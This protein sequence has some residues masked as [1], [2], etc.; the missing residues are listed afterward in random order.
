ML[1]FTLHFTS[2]A[3]VGKLAVNLIY[4]LASSKWA[5]FFTRMCCNAY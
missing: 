4:M 2:H 1:A 5:I 3:R